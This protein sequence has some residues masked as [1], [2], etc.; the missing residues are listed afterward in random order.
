MERTRRPLRL[1]TC[2]LEAAK[3]HRK[4][5]AEIT[6]AFDVMKSG[7]CIRAVIDMRSQ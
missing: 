7:D 3:A 5:L 2:L 1:C 6:S 4:T